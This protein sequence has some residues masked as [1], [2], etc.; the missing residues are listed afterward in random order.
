MTSLL[1]PPEIRARLLRRW[2]D[3]LRSHLTGDPLLPI[4]IPLPRLGGRALSDNFAAVR[5]WVETLRNGEKSDQR[6]GYRIDYRQVN[7]RRLG[8]QMVPAK[9][10]I[11]TMADFLAVTGKKQDFE[12][13]RELCDLILSA[14]PELR[15]LLVRRPNLVLEFAA[16]WPR[17][18]AVA[19]WFLEHPR[20]DCYIREMDIA[21]VD[22]KFVEGHRGI[23]TRILDHLLP[24]TAI[25]HAVQGQA[26]HGFERRF[27]LAWDQPLIRFRILDPARALA[28]LRDIAIPLADFSRL[29]PPC[30]RIFITENKISGLSFPDHDDAMVIFGL[31]YGIRSLARVPWLRERQILYWGDIDTHGFSILS[32]LR[33]YFPQVRSL[34]MDR[35]TLLRHR[36][37]WGREEE[38]KR[39]LVLPPHLE[40]EEKT[41]Y[42]DLRDN[43][44]GDNIRLEQERIR[45][46][47]LRRA[48]DSIN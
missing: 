40:P 44:I 25:D 24:E 33:G 27:G 45:F 39:H 18:L 7:H 48:L 10:V 16:A 19:A 3:V 4:S 28:G 43:R 22:S 13:F 41:L 34:L 12:K 6:P 30:G 31:G 2:P 36:E 9:I 47:C 14:Q 20:P 1:Q 8:E 32:Q 23:L 21:G 11:A 38:A 46:S 42:L 37:L 26:R 15:G 35:A 29:Q 17:L 5:A